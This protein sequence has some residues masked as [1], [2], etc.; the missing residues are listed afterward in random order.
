M[1]WTEE[2]ARAVICELIDENTLAVRPV[3]KILGWRFSEAVPTLAVT[4]SDPSE[5][6][7]NQAFVE[8]HCTEDAHLKALLLH[9]F[10][11]IL[12]GHTM[13]FKSMTPL[14][15]LA[16]DS[17]INSIIHR[18]CGESFSGFFSR[19]YASQKGMGRLLRTKRRE[20]EKDPMEQDE[21]VLNPNGTCYFRDS[22]ELFEVCWDALYSGKLVSDD[23]MEIA[24]SLEKPEPSVFVLEGGRLLIGGHGEGFD[25]AGEKL[26]E[27][28]ESA[29]KQMNGSG[30]FRGQF[31]GGPASLY[32]PIFTAQD[33]AMEKWKSQT[34]AVLKRALLPDAQGG[35]REASPIEYRLPV[36]TPSDRRAFMKGLWSPFL[37]ESRNFTV[38]EK[39]LGAANVYLDVSGSMHAEMPHI[40]SLLSSL[41][42]AI[43]MPFWAFSTEVKPAVIRNGKL[44][45]ETTGGTSIEC[46]LRHLAEAKPLCAVIVTDGYIE[47]VPQALMSACAAT[48][49]HAVVTRDGSPS[50][51]M[52]AGIPY[53]QLERLPNG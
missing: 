11:H 27:A 35:L 43:R 30:I 5:L 6:L 24:R 14:Q 32:R 38:K 18:E 16:L 47:R 19:Y 25:E 20:E 33:M 13:R 31:G 10:L 29:L 39:P 17:V 22:R 34:L 4:L 37:P 44:E 36:L 46:V 42:K 41:R 23:V 9:E 50:Q 53:L 1:R 40:I 7:I 28:L 21:L 51:L 49:I 3:L 26:R 8:E 48:K 45:T 12:L 52:Q 2:R 15:N